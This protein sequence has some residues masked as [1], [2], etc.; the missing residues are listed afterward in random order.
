[1]ASLA[2]SHTA[3]STISTYLSAVKKAIASGTL[4]G[5]P[6]D[7]LSSSLII[8]EVLEG[9][10]RTFSPSTPE[11]KTQRKSLSVSFTLEDFKRVYATFKSSPSGEDPSPRDRLLLAALS[12][13][14]GGCLR[15]GEYLRTNDT[16]R[17][18]AILSISQL[19]FSITHTAGGVTKESLLSWSQFERLMTAV[20]TPYQWTLKSITLLLRCGKTDQRRRGHEVLI[21]D[22][23]CVRLIHDYLSKTRAPRY[24][25]DLIEVLLF[26]PPGGIPIHYS[27]LRMT[28]HFREF[29]SISGVTNPKDFTLKSLRSGAAQSLLDAGASDIA[30]RA[31]GRWTNSSTPL[32]HYLNRPSQSF[33]MKE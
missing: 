6:D 31:K 21:D 24:K 30:V 9:H 18:D 29:L 16:Q 23:L 15:P 12:I 32:R 20:H 4:Q 25:G 14:L 17:P 1:L 27:A 7:P 33:A 19:S 22:P 10:A 5:D 28:R 8:K 3:P 11:A 13:G 2:E 26:E